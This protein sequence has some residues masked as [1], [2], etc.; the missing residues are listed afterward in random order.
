[1]KEYRMSLFSIH[2]FPRKIQ[3]LI[4]V[5]SH[6]AFSAIFHVNTVK[7]KLMLGKWLKTNGASSHLMVQ[8]FSTKT[9]KKA[10]GSFFCSLLSSTNWS[11]RR[12]YGNFYLLIFPSQKIHR[13]IFRYCG[14]LINFNAVELYGRKFHNIRHI[15]H[16][17]DSE[18]KVSSD[19]VGNP[20]KKCQGGNAKDKCG[21]I[22]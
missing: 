21:K 20:G 4:N 16:I 11:I 18:R 10:P 1:M 13:P 17:R 3:S 6:G 7:I 22:I 2:L 5:P 14:G 19:G 8:N 15:P 12:R 9:R